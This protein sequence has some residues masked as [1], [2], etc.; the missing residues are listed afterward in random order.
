MPQQ[1]GEGGSPARITNPSAWLSGTFREGVLYTLTGSLEEDTRL[2]SALIEVSDPLARESLNDG[3]PRLILDSFV[4]VELSL[5]EIPDA[6][7]L[8]RDFVRQNN[9]VWVMKDGILDIRPVEIAFENA[10]YAYITAG[11]E[12]GEEVVT[13]QLAMVSDG[14]ELRKNKRCVI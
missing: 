2:V 12:P 10:N 8:S 6:V 9:T 13:S 4:R 14:A 7:E 1:P 11:L 3:K 5:N